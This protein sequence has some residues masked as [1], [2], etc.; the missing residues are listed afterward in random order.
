M[1][2]PD[3]NYAKFLTSSISLALW[4]NGSWIESPLRELISRWGFQY[5]PQE[6]NYD[7]TLGGWIS[8]R[9]AG[10]S[11]VLRVV[12]NAPHELLQPMWVAMH[13]ISNFQKEVIKPIISGTVTKNYSVTGSILNITYVDLDLYDVP[14]LPVENLFLDRK[15]FRDFYESIYRF[16]RNPYEEMRRRSLRISSVKPGGFL[17]K[18]NFMVYILRNFDKLAIPES[19]I[20][21]KSYIYET[22]IYNNLDCSSLM[23][24]SLTRYIQYLKDN[25]ILMCK[26]LDVPGTGEYPFVR[27]YD[28]TPYTEKIERITSLDGSIPE[29]IYQFSTN[30]WLPLNEAVKEYGYLPTSLV[31]LAPDRLHLPIWFMNKTYRDSREVLIAWEFKQYGELLVDDMIEILRSFHRDE[32]YEKKEKPPPMVCNLCQSGFSGWDRVDDIYNALSYDC[33]LCLLG[34]DLWRSRK[35]AQVADTVEKRTEN[36]RQVP[37]NRWEIKRFISLYLPILEENLSVFL[38]EDD[39]SN[40]YVF[41]GESDEDGGLAD[42]FG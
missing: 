33:T 11:T 14:N 31:R 21:S 39:P 7:Y 28:S 24:N 26:E 32:D 23:R 5:Y 34:D 15:G 20:I 1:L 36:L 22:S 9:S 18:E 38:Q 25:H 10:L 13:K 19:M 2:A 8:I 27:S 41:A 35:L 30:P 12:E 4:D 17:D 6:C 29:G 40:S 3:I 16:N 42:M 37:R